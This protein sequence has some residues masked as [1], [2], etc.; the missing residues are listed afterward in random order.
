M[1]KKIILFIYLL[2]LLLFIPGCG[3]QLPFES[4]DYAMGTVITMRICGDNAEKV[5][6]KVLDKIHYLD[7]LMTINKSTGDA[8]NLNNMA[9]I[10]DV[11]LNPETINV[12][13]AAKKYSKL[14][15]G[16]FDITI[17][18][19]V[20]A[21]GIFTDH[22]RIPSEDEINNLKKLINYKDL[23]IDTDKNTAKLKNK[24]QMIDLGGIAKGY[25]GDAVKE[26][27]KENN[28]KSA[29]VNLGG[30]V[31][32]IGNNPEGTP[33]NVGIQN[34]RAPHGRYIGIVSVKDKAI[35]TSGDYERF[36]EKDNKRYHHI[37]D[38]KTG[39]PADSGLISATII[40]DKSIDA[41]AMSTAAFKLG[42]EKGMELVESLNDF[43]AIFITKEKE[44][45]ITSGLKNIFTFEEETNEFQ[46][47]EKR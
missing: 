5:S 44:V 8:V 3:S 12:L 6:Q 32:V 13:N 45:Y 25:A 38:G 14:S 47:V 35:V 24:N 40:A 18:P 7:D 17:G 43:E 11:S 20:K 37:L 42:L 21:W 19:L 23:I 46:F 31:V 28:I 10:S 15:D 22:P 33:W 27:F 36:F 30:N 4:E 34:P 1:A 29:Y 26:I 39:Y 9:G 41:D 16:A 2:N